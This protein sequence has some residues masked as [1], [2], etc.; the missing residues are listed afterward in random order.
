MQEAG[1]AVH[2]IGSGSR[3][4]Y[5]GKHGRARVTADTSA[6]MINVEDLDAHYHTGGYAPDKDGA[7]TRRWWSWVRQAYDS[8]K[9]IAAIC[10]GPQLAYFPRASPG[11]DM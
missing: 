5:T 3:R 6:E 8:G 9:L 11:A 4:N 10:H 7:C 2:D 1:A